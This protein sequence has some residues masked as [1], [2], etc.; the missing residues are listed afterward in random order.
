MIVIMVLGVP[1]KTDVGVLKGLISSYQK[2]VAG[3]KEHCISEDRVCV[4]FPRDLVLEGLGEEIVIRIWGAVNGDFNHPFFLAKEIA[5]ETKKHFSQARIGCF[6]SPT[7][8]WES[9]VLGPFIFQQ[10]VEIPNDVPKCDICGADLKR[11]TTCYRCTG[12]GNVTG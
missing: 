3:K 2:I 9:I 4:F 11:T 1:P 8:K 5:A 10:P 7:P 6:V 12:C